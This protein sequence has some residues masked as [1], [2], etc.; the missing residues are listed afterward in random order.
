M[1]YVPKRG[2]VIWIDLNPRVGH[3]QSGHRPALVI[4]PTKFNSKTKLAICCP[5][6]SR[7]RR[8]DFEIVLPDNLGVAGVVLAHQVRSADWRERGAKFMAR[9]P[10]EVVED[11]LIT[12]LSIID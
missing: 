1:S 5:I 8:T 3:E 10:S 7:K 6:T 11:V 4:S 2:D 12:L 9:V